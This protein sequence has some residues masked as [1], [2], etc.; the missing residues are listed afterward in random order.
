[1]NFIQ[2]KDNLP[3]NIT[4]HLQEYSIYYNRILDYIVKV[5]S[6]NKKK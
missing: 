5:I 6:K 2:K 1:M 3:F 4:K